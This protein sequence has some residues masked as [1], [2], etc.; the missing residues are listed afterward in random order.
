MILQ[1]LGDVSPLNSANYLDYFISNASPQHFANRLVS[2]VLY[3]YSFY[4]V[5]FLSRLTASVET[6]V[7]VLVFSRELSRK[8][9]LR[10]SFAIDLLT[11]LAKKNIQNAPKTFC[12]LL[13]PKLKRSFRGGFLRRQKRKFSFRHRTPAL[14]F[15]RMIV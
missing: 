13:P 10:D 15:P 3:Y 12:E 8:T 11:L 5:L 1:N 6:N 9:T 14:Y 4:K 7:S 2:L